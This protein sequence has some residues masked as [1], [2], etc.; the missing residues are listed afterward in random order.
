MT[1]WMAL[2]ADVPAGRAETAGRFWEAVTATE[3]LPA[4]G[5]HGEFVP[6]AARGED[7][8]LWVQQ[9][10]RGADDAGWHLDLFA[11]DPG[12]AA[13]TAVS[14]GARR[15]R[16]GADLVTL[17]TPAGQPF[18]LVNGHEPQ[19]HATARQWPGGHCSLLD[20]VCLDLPSPVYE[21]EARF[22]S[23]LTGWERRQADS[24]EFSLLAEP[25]NVPL[26]I[27]LQR[28]GGADTGPPRAHVDFSCSDVGAEQR[29]HE[30]LGAIVERV[31]E[32]WI[33]LR[34]PVGL[35]YC[36]TDRQ[37]AR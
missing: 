19:R 17:T 22:W 3:A 11:G 12:S 29:R 5:S 27:L 31:A 6:L 28:L 10:D 2:F 16:T 8:Y 25:R 9:V 13:A 32:H 34:D 4:H 18:C 1:G 14:L 33:T 36:I 24:P 35:R 20:Q 7:P 37:P 26:R 30:A 23:A 21:D 15:V